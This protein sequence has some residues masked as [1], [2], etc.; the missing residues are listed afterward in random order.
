LIF[1]VLFLHF[2][3]FKVSNGAKQ[4]VLQAL[5]AVVSPG[6][7]VLIPSPYWTSYPGIIISD[8]YHQCERWL[9]VLFL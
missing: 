6:E 8:F 1:F 4:A 7:E 3:C 5:L 9:F 2:D